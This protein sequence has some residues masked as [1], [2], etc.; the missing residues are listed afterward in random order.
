M[1]VL[2]RKIDETIRI[3]DDIFIT[4]CQIR[5]NQVKIGIKCP[6]ELKVQR[7]DKDHKGL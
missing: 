5:P 7:Q 6:P 2:T 3:G 4:V 1:L